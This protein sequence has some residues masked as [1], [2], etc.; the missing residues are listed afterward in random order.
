MG[1]HPHGSPSILLGKE[2]LYGPFQL[3]CM[4]LELLRIGHMLLIHSQVPEDL[5]INTARLVETDHVARDLQ[6]QL[7]ILVM[8]HIRGR[9]KPL[10]NSVLMENHVSE[11]YVGPD[12][13]L[14]SQCPRAYYTP[15]SRE[16]VDVELNTSAQF[17]R[18]RDFLTMAAPDWKDANIFV[19]NV[20]AGFTM[21]RVQWCVLLYPSV[22][23]VPHVC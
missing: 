18:T 3:D 19:A 8:H 10:P 9:L 4:S 23:L 15:D 17:F 16:T 22:C 20:L 14:S 6:R 12:Y 7:G 2:L 1:R 5:S 21:Y 11:D 13:L